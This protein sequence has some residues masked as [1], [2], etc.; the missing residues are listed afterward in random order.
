MGSRFMSA[1]S[2]YSLDFTVE[3]FEGGA[4]RS[5]GCRLQT[6]RDK[7]V[8][9]LDEGLHHAWSD[10]TWSKSS[11]LWN[12]NNCFG[13][14]CA[15]VLQSSKSHPKWVANRRRENKT[16]VEQTFG[17]N[18]ELKHLINILRWAL[19]HGQGLTLFHLHE[20]EPVWKTRPWWHTCPCA[21]WH[22]LHIS[23]SSCHEKS[24]PHFTM[25]AAKHCNYSK[26]F[27]AVF[28]NTKN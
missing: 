18:L 5:W 15:L 20:Q 22:T 28:H 11:S 10:S 21:C 27:K 4:S 17:L 14:H 6:G 23:L 26:S 25:Y 16:T 13:L 9:H 8:C 3:G 2:K 24:H 12:T 7:D 1:A 19:R